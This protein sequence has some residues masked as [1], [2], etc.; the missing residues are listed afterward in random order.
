MRLDPACAPLV[1]HGVVEAHEARL[2]LIDGK[3]TARLPA[4]PARD[5]GSGAVR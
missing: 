4:G 2:L 3:L 5:L 1:V